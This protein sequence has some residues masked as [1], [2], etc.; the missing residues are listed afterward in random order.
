MMHRVYICKI[1]SSPTFS[2]ILHLTEISEDWSK[3]SGKWNSSAPHFHSFS[4]RSLLLFLQTLVFDGV[5]SVQTPITTVS[6][7]LW[8]VVAPGCGQAQRDTNWWISHYLTLCATPHIFF[9]N[10]IKK[11]GWS[12]IR[13]QNAGQREGRNGQVEAG[14][15]NAV[16]A[17][18]KNGLEMTKALFEADSR[19]YWRIWSSKA[20]YFLNRVPLS[21]PSPLSHA[22]PTSGLPALPIPYNCSCLIPT[23]G[24]SFLAQPCCQ[25]QS[26]KRRS[27][28]GRPGECSSLSPAP[29]HASVLVLA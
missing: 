25:V 17:A 29:H 15:P 6:E 19:F 7:H 5:F 22:L 28:A 21:S 18:V 12:M 23:S 24:L 11:G 3:S 27:Q 26:G 16:G 10:W 8:G 2:L 4:L 20:Q 14:H 13:L 1:L 9:G